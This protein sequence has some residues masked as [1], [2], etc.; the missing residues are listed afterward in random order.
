MVWYRGEMA[1]RGGVVGGEALRDG[2]RGQGEDTACLVY[3]KP[4]DEAP[5]SW[6][7]WVAGGGQAVVRGTCLGSQASVLP[8]SFLP[9]LPAATRTDWSR[10]V[11]FRRRGLFRSERGCRCPPLRPLL[12]CFFGCRVPRGGEGRQ[13]R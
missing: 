7:G 8:T 3:C 10:R 2:Q 9:C 4:M 1:G 12:T 6:R 13:R 11:P 5:L